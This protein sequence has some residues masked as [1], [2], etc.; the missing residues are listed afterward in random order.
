[1]TTPIEDPAMRG[2]IRFSNSNKNISMIISR[3]STPR[4][5]SFSDRI[6]IKRQV[7]D[8]TTQSGEIRDM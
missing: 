5:R 3:E 1:L 4:G 2:R 6:K 7:R 8:S